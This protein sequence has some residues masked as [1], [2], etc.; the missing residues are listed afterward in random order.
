MNKAHVTAIVDVIGIV[1]VALG[2]YFLIPVIGV[3]APAVMV[4]IINVC[5]LG[6]YSTYILKR[7]NDGTLMYKD[8]ALLDL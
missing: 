1:V 3:L 2:C 5:I 6:F 8:R 7:I 4:F